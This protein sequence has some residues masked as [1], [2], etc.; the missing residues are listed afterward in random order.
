MCDLRGGVTAMVS[1][2]HGA[3]NR[4][5]SVFWRAWVMG[6]RW[7]K[8]VRNVFGH[9]CRWRWLRDIALQAS[10]MVNVSGPNSVTNIED[11]SIAA[12]WQT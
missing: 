11:F 5:G 4:R 3:Q 1:D 7:D 6:W 8:R 9:G 12:L 10:L 2:H